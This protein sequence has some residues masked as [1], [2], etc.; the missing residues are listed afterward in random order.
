MG[1]RLSAI[2]TLFPDTTSWY[3]GPFFAIE[4]SSHTTDNSSLMVSQRMDVFVFGSYTP[5]Q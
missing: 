3:H 5:S 1:H 2:F 4:Q